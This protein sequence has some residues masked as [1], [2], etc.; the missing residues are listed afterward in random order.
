LGVEI[1]LDAVIIG[2]LVVLVRTRFEHTI[3]HLLQVQRL[4]E[5]FQTLASLLELDEKLLGVTP[6]LGAGARANMLLDALPFLTKELQGFDK[7]EMLIHGP[8]A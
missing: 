5:V 6:R 1:G 8:A 7:A 2:V 3:S 4:E